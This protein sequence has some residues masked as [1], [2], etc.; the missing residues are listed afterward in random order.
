MGNK[1]WT[2]ENAQN[3]KGCE[4]FYIENK[5]FFGMQIPGEC[6]W[7]ESL[8]ELVLKLKR[9]IPS[10]RVIDDWE[11]CCGIHRYVLLRNELVEIV[12]GEDEHYAPIF[13]IIPESCTDTEKAKREFKNALEPLKHY[14]L[15]KYPNQ[16]YRRKNTWNL[17][18]VT[19]DVTR[20]NIRE[21]KTSG[22]S[23]IVGLMFL[24][25]GIIAWNR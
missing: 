3:L 2:P 19:D 24:K 15:R 8:S 13:L 4:G 6:Q 16:V 20:G 10:M 18:L 11:N 5:V 1:Y 17:E 7:D 23:M 25:Q 14:L 12:F 21:R 9:F 22:R